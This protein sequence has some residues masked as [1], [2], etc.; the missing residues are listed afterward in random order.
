M[1]R[2]IVMGIVFLFLLSGSFAM[3]Q[4]KVGK[5]TDVNFKKLVLDSKTLVIVDFWATW[6]GPCVKQGPILESV[7]SKTD[8]SKVKIY[9]MNV[10]E[11]TVA[12]SNYKIRSIPA[13][14]FFQNGKEVDRLEGLTPEDELMKK[15]SSYT[16]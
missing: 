14:V 2:K 11:N 3:A 9:K 4:G 12:P 15:I 7:A 6:C 13:L 10:D 16:K 1:S 8:V 5:V